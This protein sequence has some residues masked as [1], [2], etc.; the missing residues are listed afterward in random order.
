MC[1]SKQD[2]AALIPTQFARGVQET[3]QLD[4]AMQCGS[5]CARASCVGDGSKGRVH[6]KVQLALALKQMLVHVL[7]LHCCYWGVC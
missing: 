6:L 3:Y 1:I 5:M 2:T 4:E 7:L